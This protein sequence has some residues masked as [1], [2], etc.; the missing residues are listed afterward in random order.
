[1]KNILENYKKDIV[2]TYNLALP[3]IV[4]QLG[5]MLMG[6]A[7]TV[8][9]GRMDKGSVQA[10]A[11][12]ADANGILF[13]IAIIGYICLQIASPMVSQAKTE[14]N[15]SECKRLL[16]ANITV[17]LFMSII[18]SLFIVLIGFNIDILQQ[19]AEIKTST[20]EYL[21]V[22]TISLIPSFIFS[23]IKSFTDGLSHT[24]VAM[25]ITWT[26]LLMN[27]ILNYCFIN[28][29]WIFPEWGLNGTGVAT[30]TSRIYMAVAIWYYTFGTD[31][32]KEYNIVEN[33]QKNVND[34]VKKILKVGI[35]SGLQGFSEIAAFYGAVVM[36]GWISIQH[37]AA[38][39]I[40][41]GY[42]ALTY[43][44]ATGIAAAGGIRVGAG[45]GERS[46]I[47]ILR[48]GTTALGMGIAFMGVCAVVLLV[49]NNELA[50]YVKDEQV[51]MLAAQLIIWGGFFQLFDGIQC[52]SLGILR[53]MQDV[54]I[55]TLITI[56]AYWGVG[57]P[58]SYILGFHYNMQHIG[59][60]I[61]L[62]LA[63]FASASLLSW[64][65]YN[66]ANRFVN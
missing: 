42:V 19:P 65:F 9:V 1:M 43:M 59:I 7:D 6:F 38:H 23:A 48:A 56:F 16:K 29:I 62:T 46:K 10:L 8:Q 63:L 33:A 12:A 47:A 55:P 21:W 3:I 28:G 2:E 20:Q 30:L 64:R 61:G 45:M 58:M 52:V 37:K 41:I 66:K 25:N 18:C 11:A 13:I 27:V 60:W 39:Q 34:L 44:A 17:A 14:N 31:T 22:M 4:G 51:I 50:S 54:N 53:G 36:M 40:A 35:P 15:F 57:L 26:A 32:F 5:I 49:F 24:K